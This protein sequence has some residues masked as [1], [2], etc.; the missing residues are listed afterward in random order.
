MESI[1]T[2]LFSSIF[3]LAPSTAGEGKGK[4]RGGGGVRGVILTWHEEMI[5]CV[6]GRKGVDDGVWGG[7]DASRTMMEKEW[8]WK[9]VN[10]RETLEKGYGLWGDVEWSNTKTDMASE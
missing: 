2:F 3:L 9:E 10:V 6:K 7:V 5:V 1:L 4:G 8:G